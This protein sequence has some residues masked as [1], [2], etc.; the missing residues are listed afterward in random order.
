MNQ[1][2]YLIYACLILICSSLF[3]FLFHTLSVNEWVKDQ[4]TIIDID[5]V[6]NNLATAPASRGQLIFQ[7]NCGSCHAFNKVITGPALSGVQERGPW[8]DSKELVRWIKNPAVYIPTT[9]YT[10][11]LQKTYGIIM[12]S[13][14]QLSKED[15]L[16]ILDYLQTSSVHSY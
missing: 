11:G 7:Q 5:P 6:H 16:A 14:P 9:E 1:I 8:T 4:P 15:I 3:L 13:F 12:P 10:R 2:K